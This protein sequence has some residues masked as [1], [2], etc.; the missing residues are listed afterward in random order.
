MLLDYMERELFKIS[1]TCRRSCLPLR[2]IW[3]NS[4]STI[5]CCNSRMVIQNCFVAKHDIF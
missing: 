2:V 3:N 5:L 1:V 4:E